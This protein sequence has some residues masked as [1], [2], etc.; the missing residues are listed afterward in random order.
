MTLSYPLIAISVFARQLC[1]PV[2]ALFFLIAAGAFARQGQLNVVLILV[3]SVAGC[4]GGDLVWFEAGRRWGRRILR[5]FTHLADDPRRS[6]ERAHVVFGRWGLRSLLVAKFVPGLDGITP[7]LAGLEGASR[8]SFLAYDSVGSLLW[9]AG[10]VLCGYL[11][12]DQV[13]RILAFLD[14]SGSILL[15]L[16][17]I[18]LVA[19][20]VWRGLAI[21]RMVRTLK[22]KRISPALLHSRLAHGDAI[23]V[24][25]LLH[26]Q[27]GLVSAAGI[28]TALRIDPA[29][30]RSP[31]RVVVPAGIPIVLYCA[32]S[33]QFRSA[34]VAMAL[35]RKGLTEV[36]VLEGGLA[37]W[38]EEGFPV[39]M[40]LATEDEIIRRL[41]L[42]ILEP[43]AT[44]GVDAPGLAL[45]TNAALTS[46]P[47][48]SK[49]HHEHV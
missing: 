25:D 14:A 43:P 26:F 49:E 6:S 42:Q 38:V 47:Q 21:L 19:Y 41:G 13:D 31:A 32:S 24:L 35:K 45:Q 40:Q 8:A 3:M 4:L 17:V 39:T 7:P 46:G 48:T 37:R 10:Y 33:G 5:V 15:A 34:R 11:F 18:P 12:S 44:R 36:W 23:I 22:M 29:R 16:I 9:S 1:L 30:L 20:I 27:D 28:E 2:P